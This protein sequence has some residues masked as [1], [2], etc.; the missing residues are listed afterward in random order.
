MDAPH[1]RLAAVLRQRIADGTYPPGSAFPSHRSIAAESGLGVGAAYQAVAILRAEGLLAGQPRKRLFVAYAPAVRTLTDPDADW[2]H[3]QGDAETG[4]C[5]ASGELAVRLHLADRARLHWRRV[6]LLDP[7]GRPAMLQTTWRRGV[8]QP[9]H[10]SFRCEVRAHQLT[11]AESSLLGLAVGS[12][13]Y[14][15]ERTRY[16]ANG[17]PVETADLAL[18]ADRWRIAL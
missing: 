8:V 14:L 17:M 3:G 9:T 16:G 5:R 1:K 15:L 6:E 10:V 2:P 11:F 7:D 13:A 12:P 4:T 18:P